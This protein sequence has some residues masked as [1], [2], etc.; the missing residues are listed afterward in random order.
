[1]A[2]Y[3]RLALLKQL[4]LQTPYAKEIDAKTHVRVRCPICGDSYKDPTDTHC[5][6]NIEGG[7]PVSYYCFK[8][9]DGHW[10]NANFIRALGIIHPE[11][12]KWIRKYNMGFMGKES[13]KIEKKIIAG[14]G[15]VRIPSCHSTSY[16]ENK[17]RR[18]R[19]RMGVELTRNDCAKLKIILSIKEFLEVNGL[20]PMCKDKILDVLERKYLGFLSGDNSYIV[21][22]NMM[23]DEY[24]YINYPVFR[25]SGNWGSKSYILPGSINL[26]AED[27]D[28]YMTEGVFDTLGVY[29][30]VTNRAWKN[31]MYASICGAGYMALVQR[32]LHMGFIG[33][34]RLHIV[35]DQDKGILYYK[36]ILHTYG[37][38]L[39]SIDVWYNQHPGQKDTGVKKE[40]I[41]LRMAR[42]P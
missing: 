14:K 1:M 30:H 18:F 25:H 3:D 28:L 11:L 33:N 16:I 12:V 35:S 10:V 6:V 15:R 34:L 5:Y 21:F 42:N 17:L 38:R 37:K 24:R 7:K 29:F 22:R 40:L 27:I 9:S 32:V 13:L 8:C 36:N 20:V 2:D 41:D 31:T 26:M 4:L 19:S 23:D 39:K